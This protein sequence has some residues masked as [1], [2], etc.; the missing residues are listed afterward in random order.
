MSLNK[1][2]LIQSVSNK[3]KMTAPEKPKP[4][5]PEKKK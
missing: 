1:S 3:V 4:L 2:E 5:P